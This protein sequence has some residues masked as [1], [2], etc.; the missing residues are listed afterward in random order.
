M[1]AV[2]AL[3]LCWPAWSGS[4]KASP[5]SLEYA[6]KAN[7]LVRFAAFVQWPQ[8]A[9]GAPGAPVIICVLG[10][11]PFGSSLDRAVADQTVNGR[12]VRAR[13][14]SRVEA[15][16]GCHVL[17]LGRS[18]SQSAA[19]A[20]QTLGQTPVLT[21]TDS[22]IGDGRGIIHFAV[23]SNRV[24]FHVDDAAAERRGLSI[25]S[26]LLSLALSVERRS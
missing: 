4:A 10:D 19:A 15:D 24:R 22:R 18:S 11:D 20:L 25:S 7:Y 6:I 23:A 13:R 21:V 1:L 12:P 8:A 2:V 14:L 5:A 9:L 17:Y 26:R 16:S 3:G